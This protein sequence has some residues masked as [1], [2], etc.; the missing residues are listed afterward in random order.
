MKRLVLFIFAILLAAV[1]AFA[2]KNTVLVH[3]GETIYARFEV[4]GKKI[5][6][7]NA[8]TEKDEGAQVVFIFDKEPTG[9]MRRLKVENRFERDFVYKVEMRSLTQGHQQRVPS[10]PVV[11]GKVAFEEYPVGVEELA[12]YDFKI[13]R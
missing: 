4:D 11:G 7:A 9:Y 8:G 12:L 13:E 5:R 1:P 2:A 6:L 10:T 3:P